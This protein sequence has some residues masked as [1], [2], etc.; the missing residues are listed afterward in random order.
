[1]S[2]EVAKSRLQEPVKRVVLFPNQNRARFQR[3]RGSVVRD[4]GTPFKGAPL[5]VTDF[6]PFLFMGK[7][8]QGS[9]TG[10]VELPKSLT[11]R[12]SYTATKQMPIGGFSDE[13][14]IASQFEGKPHIT[15]VSMDKLGRQRSRFTDVA[16]HWAPRNTPWY[17]TT[18]KTRIGQG[19]HSIPL[20]GTAV[21]N[22]CFR[23]KP[24]PGYDQT[25]S[26]V[27]TSK[28]ALKSGS[29]PTD[30]R[31]V[32]SQVA[33][34]PAR[35]LQRGQEFKVRLDPPPPQK[36]VHLVSEDPSNIIRQQ[37]KRVSVSPVTVASIVKSV[38]EAYP[39]FRVSVLPDRAKLKGT[40]KAGDKREIVLFENRLEGL[41]ARVGPKT[42]SNR[43]GQNP[44]DSDYRRSVDGVISGSDKKELQRFAV[45]G[46]VGIVR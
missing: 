9:L 15:F 38:R 3:E 30:I 14:T 13:L 23:L 37:V 17:K 45:I 35:E 29:E 20:G 36:E 6:S 28:E 5:V 31:L 16:M 18:K 8:A 26:D 34:S 10:G 40:N 12:W 25:I 27:K 4:L 33:L 1:M 19:Y 24:W 41:I 32:L 21:S 22:G 43:V 42:A 2:P 46:D 39:S 44:T 7:G 11:N